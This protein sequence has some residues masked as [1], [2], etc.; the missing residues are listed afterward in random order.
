MGR[1]CNN[2]Y[3][4]SDTSLQA[5]I[6]ENFQNKC[7]E[8]YKF[9]SVHFNSAPEL[10]WQAA[11]RKTKVLLKLLANIDM[12]LIVEKGIRSGIYHT[13]HRFAKPNNK[14]MKDY[15]NIKHQ[16]ISCIRN[17]IICMGG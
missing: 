4:Q 9:F 6:F 5:D 10:A 8:I 7:T 15:D 1:I 16:H 12:L 11:L 14:Y 13:I 3:I 2:L 17:L